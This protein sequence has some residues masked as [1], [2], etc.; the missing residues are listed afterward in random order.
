M[1]LYKIIQEAQLPQRAPA[2]MYA[3]QGYSINSTY[4]GTNRKPVALCYVMYTVFQKKH[5]LI[6]LAIS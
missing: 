4:F 6:F 3:V 5:P 1:C 2:V